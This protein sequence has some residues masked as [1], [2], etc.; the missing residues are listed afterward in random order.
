MNPRETGNVL[1]DDLI[2]TRIDGSTIKY[3]DLRKD[4]KEHKLSP[5]EVMIHDPKKPYTAPL[6]P[7]QTLISRLDKQKS[8]EKTITGADGNPTTNRAQERQLVAEKRKKEKE[9][10][11]GNPITDQPQVKKPQKKGRPADTETVIDLKDLAGGKELN[12][13]I[14]RELIAGL[15]ADTYV[16]DPKNPE[17]KI[18]VNSLKKRY[19][20]ENNPPTRNKEAEKKQLEAQIIDPDTGEVTT[21]KKYYRNN[22]KKTTVYDGIEM[23]K[24]QKYQ[25]K[26]RKQKRQKVEEGETPPQNKDSS[27]QEEC[28]GGNADTQIP[29]VQMPNVPNIR[30]VLP[31]TLCGDKRGFHPAGASLRS[32]LENDELDLDQFLVGDEVFEGEV[33]EG[34]VLAEGSVK[35]GEEEIQETSVYYSP[36]Q[37]NPFPLYPVTTAKPGQ[38]KEEDISEE[39]ISIEK[40]Q[41]SK[42]FPPNLG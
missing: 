12:K 21:N 40:N 5:K 34:E 16:Y 23:K 26:Y 20:R 36:S 30:I 32:T 42:G 22:R 13:E 35:E 1:Q 9:P 33:L 8:R 7:L 10:G 17:A 11:T 41:S 38:R 2:I 19:S 4:V 15:N 14:I 37:P 29:N 18:K 27:P 24:N 6:I 3:S 28:A 39:D 25:L 31:E